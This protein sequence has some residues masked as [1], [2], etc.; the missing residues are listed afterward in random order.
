MRL[1]RSNICIKATGGEIQ[2]EE[3]ALCI[4][5]MDFKSCE[6]SLVKIVQRG[7]KN[8]RNWEILTRKIHTNNSKFTSKFVNIYLL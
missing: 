1:R 5:F 4:A 7:T 3:E 6:L 8:S 2:R